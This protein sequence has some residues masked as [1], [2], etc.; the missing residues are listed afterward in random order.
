MI[1]ESAYSNNDKNNK[2][3]DHWLA[4]SQQVAL[5]I[6]CAALVNFSTA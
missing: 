1:A 2:K 4:L 5:A 6:C 3:E